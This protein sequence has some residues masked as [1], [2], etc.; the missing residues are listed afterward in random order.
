MDALQNQVV[1]QA[2]LQAAQKIE[3]QLDDQLH[4]LENMGQ[5]D[6]ERLRQQ[7][8]QVCCWVYRK[9]LMRVPFAMLAMM[10]VCRQAVQSKLQYA[11]ASRRTW[12]CLKGLPRYNC[13]SLLDVRTALA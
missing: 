2:V 13:A 1:E 9:C 7:R 8:M 10:T 11:H 5:D 4:A 3:D 6:V 12:S